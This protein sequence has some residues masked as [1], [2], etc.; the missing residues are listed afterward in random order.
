M[1]IAAKRRRSCYAYRDDLKDKVNALHRVAIPDRITH[2]IYVCRRQESPTGGPCSVLLLRAVAITGGGRV[3]KV[4][5]PLNAT[6]DV[7]FYDLL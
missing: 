5:G 7:S 4:W 3:E 1:L 6:I 2:E